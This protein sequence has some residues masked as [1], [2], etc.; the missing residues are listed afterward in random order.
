MNKCTLFS[1][2][3]PITVSAVK[4]AALIIMIT[5]TPTWGLRAE[6]LTIQPLKD[7]ERHTKIKYTRT[8]TVKIGGLKQYPHLPLKLNSY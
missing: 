1:M 6:R 2:M 7:R 8:H 4:R 3:T 5:P